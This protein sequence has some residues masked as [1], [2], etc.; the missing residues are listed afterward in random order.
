MMKLC[1][2]FQG[3]DMQSEIE[4]MKEERRKYYNGLEEIEKLKQEFYQPAKTKSEEISK[5]Y[6]W[7]YYAN[8]SISEL[9]EY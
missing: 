3:Y 4:R 2:L 5:L 6:L 7:L 1:I 8:M 9:Y